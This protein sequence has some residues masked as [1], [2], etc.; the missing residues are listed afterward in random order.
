MI[1]QKLNDMLDVA[2]KVSFS[3]FISSFQKKHNFLQI[4]FITSPY[5]FLALTR[6]MRGL[7]TWHILTFLNQTDAIH[8]A[9]L[10]SKKVL[11][12]LFSIVFL[13]GRKGILYSLMLSHCGTSA[14]TVPQ[15]V[16]VSLKRNIFSV[17]INTFIYIY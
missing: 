7:L 15:P 10:F 2:F 11:L 16:S 17:S 6:V 5:I 14:S 12:L 9:C 13:I 4:C 8:K 3:H 1:H